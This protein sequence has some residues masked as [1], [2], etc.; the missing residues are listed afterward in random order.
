MSHRILLYKCMETE[1]DKNGDIIKDH[2]TNLPHH[3]QIAK[4]M[5]ESWN[6][7]HM[8]QYFDGILKDKISA[9]TMRVIKD[10]DG[11]TVA[12]ITVH[13]KPNVRFS[14]KITD[15]IYDQLDGQ[16]SD[17]WGEGFFGFANIMTDD[18]G[19]EFCVE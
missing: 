6:N 7:A 5:T 12:R 16:L 13:G 18:D 19:N 15:A 14:S 8:E 11:S 17:G 1:F 9:A 2:K 10:S 3:D 4:A